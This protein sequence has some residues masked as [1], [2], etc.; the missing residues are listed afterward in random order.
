MRRY[1]VSKWGP[2]GLAFM[3]KLSRSSS[4]YHRQGVQDLQEGV[5]Y[6]YI[7]ILD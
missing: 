1:L 6:N 2:G 3:Q 5:M 4:N 7:I